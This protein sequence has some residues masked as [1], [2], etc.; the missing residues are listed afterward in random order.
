MTI[1]LLCQFSSKYNLKYSCESKSLKKSLVSVGSYVL[2]T[3]SK[4][5]A[6]FCPHTVTSVAGGYIIRNVV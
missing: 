5:T 4:I 6:G 2:L 1:V 3:H